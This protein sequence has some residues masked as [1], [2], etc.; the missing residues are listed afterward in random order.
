MRYPTFSEFSQSGLL[1]PRLFSP[2]RTAQRGPPRS[3]NPEPGRSTLA[4]LLPEALLPEA[5]LL[6]AILP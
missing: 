5:L 4:A 2:D 6:E 3:R 1:A